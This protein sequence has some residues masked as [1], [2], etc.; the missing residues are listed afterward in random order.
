MRVRPQS[1]TYCLLG[2]LVEHSCNNPK[3]LAF[4]Y[5]DEKPIDIGLMKFLKSEVKS[6]EVETSPV[7]TRVDQTPHMQSPRTLAVNVKRKGTTADSRNITGLIMAGSIKLQPDDGPRYSLGIWL[8][9]DDVVG[10]HRKFARR[11]VEGNR[12]LAR[13]AKRDSRKED[14]R[15][16]R[17]I[18]GGCQSIRDDSQ[19]VSAG[20][21]PRW[22][23]DRPYHRL[24]A[25]AND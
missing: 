18:V 7:V 11:F 25:T 13:N 15:T 17:K 21:P 8:N 9:S 5:L 1:T 12:K 6:T 19:Q 16:C 10:S 24:R 22:R 4:G 2:S 14:R 23:L 20:K 3:F